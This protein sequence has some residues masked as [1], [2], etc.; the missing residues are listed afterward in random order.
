MLRMLVDRQFAR[1]LCFIFMLDAERAG[2]DVQSI[3][4]RMAA[5]L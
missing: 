3:K 5:K 1:W 2:V 4:E